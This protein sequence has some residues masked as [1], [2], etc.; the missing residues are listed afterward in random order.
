M[1]PFKLT[2]LI[3]VFSL[4]K[5]PLLGLLRPKVIELSP[6][7]SCVR[8]PLS[9]IAKNHVGSMYFGALAMGAE[10][11]VALK[12]VDSMQNQKT[13]VNFIFK[14]F[15]CQFL[16]RA[17]SDTDFCCDEVEK[18]TALVEKAL[19]SKQRVEERFNGYALPAKSKSDEEKLMT[20]QITIS[21]K[22][23][24]K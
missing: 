8:L 15:N 21:I 14:D 16:K 6:Q 9:F 7:R 20:Y 10:L 3:Q 5:V 2:A 22:P 24:G 12:V 23:T 17:M 11:S 18:I 4:L 19:Q 13:P 1:S